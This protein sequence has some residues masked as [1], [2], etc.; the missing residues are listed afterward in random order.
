MPKDAASPTRSPTR[1]SA[2]PYPPRSDPGS[3]SSSSPKA[4]TMTADSSLS[5]QDKIA[6]AKEHKEA[7]NAAFK[8]GDIQSALRSYHTANLFIT[9]LD[10]GRYGAL[11]PNKEKLSDGFRA[12]IEAIQVS[13]HSNIAACHFKRQNW[14]KVI[15]SCD[16]VL[17]MDENNAKAYYR[18][19][20]ALLNEGNLD[21]A[22]EDLRKALSLSPKDS[23]V[24]Q[25]LHRLREEQKKAEEKQKKEFAGMFDRSVKI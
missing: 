24:V 10:S 25:E 21:R 23:A 19:G 22:E 2:S 16:K 3:S 17:S 11:M 13:C 7:G 14:T 9:G 1:S 5:I 15:A 4:K 18:R 8:A 6:R 12:E 20:A